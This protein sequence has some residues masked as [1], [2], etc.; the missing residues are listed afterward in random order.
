MILVTMFWFGYGLSLNL[1]ILMTQKLCINYFWFFTSKF[2][3]SSTYYSNEPI[4]SDSENVNVFSLNSL[5]KFAPDDLHF[6]DLK[7][8]GGILHGK[9]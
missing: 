7:E 3:K 4:F 6:S 5:L 8:N 9:F 2:N 1:T